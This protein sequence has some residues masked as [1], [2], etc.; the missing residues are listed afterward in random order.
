MASEHLGDHRVCSISKRKSHFGKA[1]LCISDGETF[2]TFEDTSSLLWFPT[3][4]LY[5]HRPVCPGLVTVQKVLGVHISN[6]N[7]LTF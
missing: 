6:E 5:E 2:R 7:T 3:A 4:A 1:L